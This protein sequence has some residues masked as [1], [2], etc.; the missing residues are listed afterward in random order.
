MR[1]D[2]TQCD[3]I[4]ERDKEKKRK[5]MTKQSDRVRHKEK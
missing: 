3:K 2:N 5:R 1:K 4:K